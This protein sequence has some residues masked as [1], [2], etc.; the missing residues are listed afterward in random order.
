[1]TAAAGTLR[2]HRPLRLPSAAEATAGRG[3]VVQVFEPDVGGVPSYVACL[4]EGLVARG[5]RVTVAGP[6]ASTASARLAASGAELVPL[7]LRHRPALS[8]ARALSSL[9]RLCTAGGARLIHAHST[10]ASLLGAAA[11]RLS[12]VPSVYTAHAWAFERTGPAAARRAYAA[13]ERSMGRRHRAVIAVAESERRRAESRGI[14]PAAGIHVVLTGHDPQ[15]APPRDRARAALGLPPH[16]PVVS[17]VG[18]RAP[19]KRP[20]DLAPLAAALSADGVRVVALGHWLAGSPEGDA[21]VA[22]G[23]IVAPEGLPAAALHA[24]AD[25]YVQTSAWEGMPI[26]VL[27]AMHAALPVVAYR[28]GGLPEQVVEGIT[29]HLLEQ[30]DI[31]GLAARVLELVRSP[32]RRARMGEAGRGLAAERFSVERMLDGN[33]QVYERIGATGP[34]RGGPP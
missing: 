19:Q 7:A 20:Q 24:A 15:P 34:G 5:W 14:A 32:Q 16:V 8:D 28:V 9:V 27:E 29:G 13:F 23:G 12:G 31:D 18:R 2:E 3:H 33:E 6:P 4:A 30:E 22:A 25:V 17:W 21:L 10:K 1:M 11:S 26:A